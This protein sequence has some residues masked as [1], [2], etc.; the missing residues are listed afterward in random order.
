MGDDAMRQTLIVGVCLLVSVSQSAGLIGETDDDSFRSAYESW[1]RVEDDIQHF[2]VRWKRILERINAQRTLETNTHEVDNNKIRLA[3]GLTTVGRQSAPLY[4]IDTLKLLFV[5]LDHVKAHE[6]FVVIHIAHRDVQE[7]LNAH[8]RLSSEFKE[9]VCSEQLVILSFNDSTSWRPRELLHDDYR[10]C[11]LDRNYHDTL[12][13]VRWRSS[14]VVN[15]AYLWYAAHAEMHRRFGANDTD[16]MFYLHLEDDTPPAHPRTWFTDMTH[17]ID[18]LNADESEWC[19]LITRHKRRNGRRSH[20]HFDIKRPSP[21]ILP[22]GYGIL[23]RHTY[24]DDIA[25]YFRENFDQAPFDYLSGRYFHKHKAQC[26]IAFRDGKDGLFKHVGEISSKNGWVMDDEPAPRTDPPLAI[27]DTFFS[28]E[29]C[30]A[31]K[32]LLLQDTLHNRKA[33][34]AV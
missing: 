12:T 30:D 11:S 5:G 20:R 17:T 7:R 23:V 1:H 22:G 2:R 26:A 25:Q 6:S 4:V 27:N 13:R 14:I 9:R 31:T 29:E 34:D 28:F 24:V 8:Q 16:S 33:V 21:P 15:S 32:T 19:M 10:S 18:W 3:I